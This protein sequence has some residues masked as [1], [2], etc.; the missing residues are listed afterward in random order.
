[1]TTSSRKNYNYL[2][3]RGDGTD[4]MEFVKTFNLDPALAYTPE[5]NDAMLKIAHDD[6]VN[7]G[8]DPKMAQQKMMAAKYSIRSMM[9]S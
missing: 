5:I 3:L 2:A 7:A 9:K 6:N 4:D 1:M 8:M